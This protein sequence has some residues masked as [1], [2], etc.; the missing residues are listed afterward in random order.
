MDS[1]I[2]SQQEQE[3]SKTK[4]DLLKEFTYDSLPK[5]S[6]KFKFKVDF[7]MQ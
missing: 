6:F 4:E 1:Q 3:E 2:K 7:G 5:P